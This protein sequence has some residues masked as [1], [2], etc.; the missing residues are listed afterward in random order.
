M[1]IYDCDYTA[2]D[3]KTVVRLYCIDGEEER[4]ILD[5]SHQPYIYAI[6]LVPDAR[7]RIEDL[8]KVSREK[9]VQAQSVVGAKRIVDGKE[10]AVLQ[11]FFRYPFDVPELR[12]DIRQYADIYEY[13]IPFIRRYLLDSGIPL[14]VPVAIKTEVRDGNEYLVSVS[15]DGSREPPLKAISLDIETYKRGGSMP[16]AKDDPIIMVSTA[17]GTEAKVFSW[18]ECEG[19]CAY[20]DEKGMLEAV[21]AYLDESKARIV[22]TYNGDNFDLPYIKKRC[23]VLGVSHPFATHMRIKNRGQSASAEI[24]GLIHMD[25]YPIVR[26][27]VNLPRYTLEVVYKEYLGKDKSDIPGAKIWKYW[28]DASLLSTLAT[29]SMEDAV[30]TYE[31]GEQLLPLSYELAKIVN[32]KLFDVGRASSSALV[33]WLLMGRCVAAGELI[34]NTPSSSDLR[35]RFGDT[36]EGAYVVE[37]VKGV[38]DHIFYFDFRSLYPSIIISHNVDTKTIDCKCCRD[39]VAPTGHWFCRNIKGF[40]PPILEEL[41]SERYRIKKE[42]KEATG[43]MKQSLFG[44][45]WALKILAN[46][47]Y[48]YLGYPRSR[49]YS[50][51]SAESITAWGRQYIGDVIEEAGHEGYLVV[52]GDTDSLFV[53]SSEKDEGKARAFLMHV[54]ETLPKTMELEMEGYFRRGVFVTKKKYALIDEEGVITTKGLEVV[55]RDWTGIAKKTQQRVLEKILL[56]GD[57]EGA[58]ALVQ[59]VTRDI[60]ENNVPVKDLVIDTQLT[61]GLNQYKTEG[62]HVAIA[63]LLKDR[64]EDIKMGSI[65][66]YLVLKGSG[67]IRDKAIPA[68]D[69]NGETIDADYYIQ[70][71]VLPAVGRILEPLGYTKEDLEYHKTR[72]SSLEGWF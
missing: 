35:Q 70:N 5:D 42:M 19:A 17:D 23:E 20:A 22:M 56:D 69:Y 8:V 58:K 14:L 18:K 66:S 32:Q 71:Q 67:R 11:I 36:Y 27:N 47:F 34:P 21:F 37:P 25:L 33:E 16:S 15:A 10:T 60:K 9:V 6:P 68:A 40:I 7:E 24:P 51:E 3:D 13:D 38:H 59:Q 1:I 29:Y 49:W 50:K 72:Q 30:A 54:N 53:S 39:N 52:Y 57:V 41:L 64:G 61:M 62:P 2:M 63:R 45:Q 48:G 26:K 65:I 43:L 44:Q 46:S 28:E 12:D 4:I 31:I 55:R